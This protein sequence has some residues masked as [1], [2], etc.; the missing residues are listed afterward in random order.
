MSS[1]NITCSICLSGYQLNVLNNTCTLIP[2]CYIANCDTCF[3]TVRC[4]QCNPNFLPS[5]FGD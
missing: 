2:K 5:I 3:S 1:S 4:G